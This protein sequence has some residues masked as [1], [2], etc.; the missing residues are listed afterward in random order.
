MPEQNNFS[1]APS[2]ALIIFIGYSDDALAEAQAIIALSVKVQEKLLARRL[3]NDDSFPFKSVKMWEWRA[4]STLYPGGQ[5]G[6]DSALQRADIAV[7]VFKERVGDGTWGELERCC[8]RE[9]NKIIPVLACFPAQQPPCLNEVAAAEDWV[10]LLKKCQS[11]VDWQQAGSMALKPIEKYRDTEHLKEIILE[12]VEKSLT[13]VISAKTIVSQGMSI[14]PQ[15]RSLIDNY[16]PQLSFDKQ[17]AS[18]YEIADLDQAFIERLLNTKASQ[19]ILLSRVGKSQIERTDWDRCLNILGCV[20]LGKPNVGALLCMAP[21]DLLAN[22]FECCGLQRVIYS[23]TTRGQSSAS[24]HL[25]T[26]NLIELFEKGKVW[27]LTGAGLRHQGRVRTEERD[28]LEI[29]DEV[30]QEALAN[31]LIHRNYTDDDLRN[32][33]VRLEV[34]SDRIVI[35]SPG[36][37]PPVVN[38]E[39][40]NGDAENVTPKRPNP[41]IAKIFQFMTFVDLNGSG[42]SHMQNLM[43]AASLPKPEFVN[44]IEG[45]Y[46]KVTLWRPKDWGD[47]DNGP[48]I[49]SGQVGELY[50]ALPSSRRPAQSGQPRRRNR[51][52]MQRDGEPKTQL[53][54]NTPTVTKTVAISS[55]TQDWHGDTTKFRSAV[56]EACLRVGAT[57]K[58]INNVDATDG[59]AIMQSCALIEQADV[60]IGLI[61]HQYGYVPKE[62]NPHGI[63]LVEMEYELAVAKGIPIFIFLPDE[64][65]PFRPKDMDVGEAEGKLNAFK[66]RLGQRHQCTEVSGAGDLRGKVVQTLSQPELR[67]TNTSLHFVAEIPPKPKDYVAHDYA[68]LAN[69]KLFG[70]QREMNLLTDWIVTSDSEVYKSHVLTVLAFGGMGKSALTWK[71]FN[72]VAPFEAPQWQ[73]RIWWSFYESDS[74]FDNF[75]A[76]TLAYVTGQPESAVR[77]LSSSQRADRLFS[78]LNQNNYLLVLDGVERILNAYARLDASRMAD[79]DLDEQTDHYVKNALLGEEMPATQ[80]IGKNWLRMATDPTARLFF[81]KLAGL[82]KSRVLISSRLYPSDLQEGTGLPKPGTNALF[83]G[84]LTDADAVEMWRASRATGSRDKLLAL[85]KTFRNYPLL[86]KTLAR[87]IAND[88]VAAGDY[89]VWRQNHPNFDPFS[90]EEQLEQVKT[91]VLQF[92]L[93]GL[94][95][96]CQAALYI[97]ATFRIP[98]SYFVLQ[99]LLL[100]KEKLVK[101]EMALDRVLTVLEDSGLLAWDRRANR[102][103]L[104]PVVRGITWARMSQETRRR[105]LHVLH[106]LFKEL[107]NIEDSKIKTVDDLSPIIQDFDILVNLGQLSEASQLFRDQLDYYLRYV[108]NGFQQRKELLE[109][110]RNASSEQLGDDLP[111]EEKAFVLMALGESL[112]FLGRPKEGADV[113]QDAIEAAKNS[114]NVDLLLEC[115]AKKSSALCSGGHL[116]DSEKTVLGAIQIAQDKKLSYGTFEVAEAFLQLVGSLYCRAK[117]NEHPDVSTYSAELFRYHNTEVNALIVEELVAE[118]NKDFAKC[119]ELCERHLS[120]LK[121]ERLGYGIV[122]T[123]ILLGKTLRRLQ[124]P[125][126]EEFLRHGIELARSGNVIYHCID[127]QIELARLRLEQGDLESAA[128]LIDATWDELE[129]CELTLR[130]VDCLNVRAQIAMQRGENTA[131]VSDAQRAYRLAWC[132]GPP[133]AYADGLA[134]AREILESLDAEV[135]Q[136]LKVNTASESELLGADLTELKLEKPPTTILPPGIT[137]TKGWT[138]EQIQQKLVEVKTQLDWENTT[139][140]AHKWWDAFENENKPRTTLVLRLAEALQIRKATITEFFL[141]YVYSNT[142]NIQ[143]N[144]CYLDYTRLKKEE[145]KK[146][147]EVAARGSD[148]Q[149][150]D[151]PKEQTQE[152]VTEE[153]NL[154]VGITDTKG[155]SEEQLLDKLA[156]V[157]T[158]LDW[159]NTTGSAR[160]WWEAFENENKPRTTLVLRLAEELQIRKA[161]ITE[162]FLAYVYSNTDNIQA[163]LHYLD[164]T[165]L[166]KEEERKRREAAAKAAPPL[167]EEREAKESD[168]GEILMIQDDD[169]EE[170]DDDE[171]DND[172]EDNNGENN[173]VNEISKN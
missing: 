13:Y 32:E 93:D 126:T 31:A 157:K 118:A 105:C 84:G 45:E 143:A 6:V 154:P 145:E 111:D 68:L 144:L 76:R 106:G 44:N 138:G 108:V 67:S 90:L 169:G 124:D 10:E 63:S 82:R 66:T 73:G 173:K 168:D 35:T 25:E 20:S 47:D 88:K 172:D 140:S 150:E 156:E 58:F 121:A 62:D 60:F 102:Y 59:E 36:N 12:Q 101:D 159:D 2:D 70:R 130:E 109:G 149:G 166:K 16:D 100:G 146:R 104:H 141:A 114:S 86:I 3:P 52:T 37:L 80:R 48:K 21:I 56:I 161:T 97:V 137:D 135:P 55:A 115:M 98:A 128:D 15:P 46:V 49:S 9:D 39:D 7:F 139:G 8:Q 158:Q 103:D 24:L 69:N 23:G 28:D 19:P 119:Q 42:V 30:L 112:H 34:F 77:Q 17:R 57:P 142:D 171:G 14:I 40:L 41:I 50:N 96:E 53:L 71:W 11:L 85:F 155:W 75:V 29:P 51:R 134:E 81:R 18:M 78:E 123:T 107:R 1:D 38:V 94:D 79:S 43:K 26:G 164:Y 72:D 5:K 116:L 54:L 65:V 99:A 120:L 160:K 91:H 61:A 95:A 129:G 64:D 152:Q 127:G 148:G 170:D 117:L 87:H 4:D 110:L 151:T 131:A 33:P 125:A 27:L 165:R 136:G 153:T 22:H 163:N 167:S 92:A 132:D 162:F 122:Q 89:D 147:R 83:L 74:S 133:F 113:L